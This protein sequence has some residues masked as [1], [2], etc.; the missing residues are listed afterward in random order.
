MDTS[1]LGGPMLAP[2]EKWLK[3]AKKGQ[4]L[5]KRTKS[6]LMGQKGPTQAK[7][8]LK[9]KQGANSVTHQTDR[10]KQYYI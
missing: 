9:D 8:V 10:H 4:K 3:R 7:N 6:V 1:K 5:L 2:T